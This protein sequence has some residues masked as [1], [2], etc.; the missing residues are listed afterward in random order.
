M[1]GSGEVSQNVL[2]RNHFYDVHRLPKNI[3][4]GIERRYIKLTGTRK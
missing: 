2:N 4:K 1:V 3:L